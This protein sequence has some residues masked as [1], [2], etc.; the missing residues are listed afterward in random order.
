MTKLILL[1]LIPVL[2]TGCDSSTNTPK[3]PSKAQTSYREALSNE[4][5]NYATILSLKYDIPK[6]AVKD[7][8]YNVIVSMDDNIDLYIT[9]TLSEEDDKNF[10]PMV[11]R[12]VEPI[13]DSIAVKYGIPKRAVA[14]VYIDYKLLT[15]DY[16]PYEGAYE[17][18]YR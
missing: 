2:T 11:V 4:K 16:D 17:D 1:L 9:H 6:Q 18:D 13:I 5:N 8:I 12:P 7:V 14:A 10:D 15:K 3:E